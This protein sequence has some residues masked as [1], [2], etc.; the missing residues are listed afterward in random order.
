METQQ[1]ERRGLLERMLSGFAA[2]MQLRIDQLNEQDRKENAKNKDLILR[3]SIGAIKNIV[4]IGIMASTLGCSRDNSP[5]KTDRYSYDVAIS[6]NCTA[7]IVNFYSH[8]DDKDRF[9]I[10]TTRTLSITKKLDSNQVVTAYLDSVTSKGKDYWRLLRIDGKN[11][12]AIKPYLTENKLL[13]IVN[14]NGDY[15]D[16]AFSSF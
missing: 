6:S 15:P 5:I 13:A 8:S 1:T 12:D 16:Y 7:H 3:K 4:A 11:P 2:P 9:S 10:G 14:M